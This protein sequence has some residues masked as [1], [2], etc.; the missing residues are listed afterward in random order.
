M[1]QSLP[2]QPSLRQLKNQAKDLLQALKVGQ[3]EALRRFTEATNRAPGAKPTL[4]ESQLV[5]A[6][7][8]GFASWAALKEEV[9]RHEKQ[10]EESLLGRFRDAV[11]SG[12]AA[13]LK[14]L[15]EEHPVLKRKV[16]DS[17]FDFGGSAIL[18][19]VGRKDRPMI[20][21][22]LEVGAD[23]NQKSQWGPGGFG[24][25]DRV[26]DDLGEYLISRG[27]GIDAHAAAHLGK[28]DRL[29]ELL[30]AIPALA[31]ARGGD[32]GSPLHF[33]RNIEVV[34]LLLQYGADVSLRDRDHGSTAA[35]WLIKNKPVLYRLSEAGSPI[36][37]F[38]ACV[39]GDI[40]LAERALR[41]DPAC[42]SAF[43]SHVNGQ[44]KFAPDT[45]GNI[46]NWEIGHAA[47][48]I[49]VAAA[50]GHRALVDFLLGQ[51]SPAERLV[52]HCL[53]G[54]KE[55]VGRLVRDHPDL[56]SQLTESDARALPDAVHFRKR[57]AA[58]L[59]VD[60]GFPIMAKGVDEADCLHLAAWHGDAELAR[61]AI[62]K[63]ARVENRGNIRGGTPL[64]GACHGSLHCWDRDKGNYA[65]VVTALIQAGADF[66]KQAELKKSGVTGWASAQVVDAI[67]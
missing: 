17:L 13:A 40:A 9:E 26:D 49:P 24:V 20:D 46:Y 65:E 66:Q 27:A 25:L 18:N 35:M 45:G 44:G 30:A 42:L 48:P 28:T 63:G 8:Y 50:F 55:A 3:P 56:V 6:R 60:A 57:E 21:A 29:R 1:S 12:N 37:I 2:A 47:R 54:D 52:A 51:A 7:E 38:M 5:L 33:A 19:A 39:H 34:E 62:A 36:D 23:L 61:L 67:P 53:M 22:L 15:L 41:E 11:R 16:N 4:S 59:M 31:N 43:I 64:E 10:A 14:A 32:G 58:K